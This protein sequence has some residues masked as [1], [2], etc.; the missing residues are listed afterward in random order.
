MENIGKKPP[1]PPLHR[2]GMSSN[3]ASPGADE[4][5]SCRSAEAR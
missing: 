2:A 3:L 4:R 5:R 1:V